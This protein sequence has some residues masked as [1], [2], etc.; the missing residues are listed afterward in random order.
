MLYKD[1]LTKPKTLVTLMC[2]IQNFSA[3]AIVF[4]LPSVLLDID[5]INA[6]RYLYVPL[7]VGVVIHAR[8]EDS[9]ISEPLCFSRLCAAS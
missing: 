4:Y 3:G 2:Q 5:P 7:P 1:L 9:S 6:N 8:Y